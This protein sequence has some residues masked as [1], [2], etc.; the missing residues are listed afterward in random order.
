MEILVFKH[1]QNRFYFSKRK[2]FMFQKKTGTFGFDTLPLEILEKAKLHLW[3]FQKVVWD[4]LEI[5]R[6]ITKTDGNSTLFFLDHCWK[7]HFFFNLPMEFQH[8]LFLIPLGNSMSS[9]PALLFGF[10]LE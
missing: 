1:I 2:Y 10:F 3:I 7:F 4:R 6:Q 8:A 5:P 9:A